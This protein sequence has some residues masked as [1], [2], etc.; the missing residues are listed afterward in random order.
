MKLTKLFFVALFSF[1]LFSCSQD[2]G[3]ISFTILQIND[4]YE[5]DA[6]QNNQFGGMARVETLRQEL[7]EKDKNT[8]FMIAGD[9]LNPSL[10][11]TMKY[12]GKKI[13]G[14]Q[15]VEVMN[16]MNMDLAAFGNHEFDVKE[17]ELQERL[18]ESNFPWISANVFHVRQEQKDTVAFYQERNGV[19]NE[20]K[21]S[22]I[23]EMTDEDGT[24][25]KVGFISVCI[26]SNPKSHVHYTNMFDEIQEEYNSIK[27]QVDVVLGL[28]HVK[29]TED[30]EI[31]RLLPNI[32]LIMGGHEHTRKDRKVGNVIIKKADANAKSAF[33]HT[34]RFDKASQA[35]SVDSQYKLIDSTVAFNARIETIVKKWDSIMKKEITKVIDNPDEVI[36]HAKEP[37]EGRDTPIRSE[38]TNLGILIAESMS[39]SY[40]DQVDC[41]F[42][43]G[44]GI[45]IDDVLEGE[46]RSIDIFRV[47]PYGGS[48]YKVQM[49][50][51]LLIDVLNFG[52]KARGTGAYL[53]REKRITQE[54]GSWMISGKTIQPNKTYTIATIDF[55]LKGLDIPFLTKDHE[56]IVSIYQPKEDEKAYDVRKGVIE[57]M[58]KIDQ[59]K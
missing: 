42:T 7:L 37:L 34:I 3:K 40:D 4:V 48:V 32:P 16:A 44:G 8:L 23:K 24:T 43:N 1:L 14:R 33:I 6:I 53:Q 57:Y 49:K 41:S 51:S 45:R 47:L 27:D 38:Q 2:D 31:A 9:F 11:G 35:T 19:K 52:E 22:F 5:I 46:V 50:G 58:K 59:A 17:H 13:S 56:G 18:N 29:V 28:T 10:V 36:Y 30:E 54:N 12:E 25:I 26:P 15:M 20:V 55:L 21:G 39:F